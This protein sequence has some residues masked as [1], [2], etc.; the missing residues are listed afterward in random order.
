M[1]AR[2]LEDRDVTVAAVGKKARDYFKRRSYAL[3]RSWLDVFRNVDFSTAKKIADDVIQ[4]YRDQQLDEIYRLIPLLFDFVV[5]RSVRVLEQ[6]LP[7]RF[8]PTV[9]EGDWLFGGRAG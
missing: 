9:F 5:K 6:G 8:S 3:E 2:G 4:L 7:R 1:F